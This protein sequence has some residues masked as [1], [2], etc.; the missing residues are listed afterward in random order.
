M[1]T[2][3]WENDPV[4]QA[5]RTAGTARAAE[6]ENWWVKDSLVQTAPE[7]K[8]EPRPEDQSFLRSVADVPLGLTKGAV[9]GVRLIADAFGANN[10]VS[11]TIRGVED[12]VGGLMSAQS[13]NDAREMARIMK[14]AEDKGALDQ[15]QAAVKAISVAPIDTLTQILGTA[16]P[17][18]IG[19]VGAALARAGALAATGVS[20][21]IGAGMGAG[22]VKSTIFDATKEEL[23]K[24]KVPEAEAIKLAEQA[25]EYGGK[26][27]DQILLGA[28]FGVLGGAT[29]IEPALAKAMA[30]RILAKTATEEAATIAAETAAKEAAKGRIR[31]GVEGAIKESI[32]EALQAGQEQI[33][34]NIA[35][36]R[37][38][39]DVPTM[40]GVVGAA[41]LEGL[42]GA[43][44]G[45]GIGARGARRQLSP[46]ATK[47][48]RL[49]SALDSAAETEGAIN[50]PERVSVESLGDVDR[51]LEPSDGVPVSPQATE[52]RAAETEAAGLGA[53]ERAASQLAERE[54]AV[55]NTLVEENGALHD[56]IGATLSK[57]PD[58]LALMERLD[59]ELTQAVAA[60][61][62]DAT[63]LDRVRTES[64]V[65]KAFVST[66]AVPATVAPTVEG[67]TVSPDTEGVTPQTKAEQPQTGEAPKFNKDNTPVPSDE[68]MRDAGLTESEIEN[69]KRKPDYYKFNQI[70][71]GF[72]YIAGDFKQITEA[73]VAEMRDF[74]AK[75]EVKYNEDKKKLDE[76][77]AKNDIS[78]VGR[79]LGSDWGGGGSQAN[80]K[81][82]AYAALSRK[83]GFAASQLPSME[84]ILARTQGTTTTAETTPSVG[85]AP[86]GTQIKAPATP[87]PERIT[88]ADLK[89]T[90]TDA[91]N[92]AVDVTF[93]DGSKQTIEQLI[94]PDGKKRWFYEGADPSEG[95][96]SLQ[97]LGNNTKDALLAL[98]Q[99]VNINP[100]FAEKPRTGEPSPAE[101]E[102][103]NTTVARVTGINEAVA[104]AIR[105]EDLNGTLRII[106]RNLTG[107]YSELATR[108]LNL[109]L[110][111][112]I[113]FDKEVLLT[114]KA[115]DRKTS[116]AQN[117][118]FRYIQLTYPDLYNKFFK[119]FDKESQLE[120]VYQGLLFL[121]SGK[122][123]VDPVRAE[124]TSVLEA[125]ND[126]MP[127]LRVP[128]VFF[129]QFD[130]ISL[131]TAPELLRW[132]VGRVTYRTVLHEVAHAASFYAL[133]ADPSEL[134]PQQLKAR[135]KLFEMFE[136]AKTKL[137]K[138]D[139]YGMTD[140]DEFVSEAFT[141][142]RFQDALKSIPYKDTNASIFSRFVRAILDFFGVDN[143]AGNVMLQANELFSASRPASFKPTPV[144]AKKARV[145]KGPITSSWRT[146]ADAAASY[147]IRLKNAIQG[148]EKWETVLRDT[149]KAVWSTGTGAFRTALLGFANLRQLGDLTR[150]KFPQII[151]AINVIEKMLADRGERL[152]KA[153]D[154]T[155]SWVSLQRKDPAQS[156]LMGRIMLE[157]T[158]QGVD[159][160]TAQPGQLS[161][162]FEEAWNGLDGEFKELYGKV[163]D[164]Y[165]SSL[166]EMI[167][168]IKA[169]AQQN[170]NIA[171][172]TKALED[173][174]K[175]FGPTK[176]KG[177]YFPLRRF[178]QYSYQVGK[179]EN[180]EFYMFES[181]AERDLSFEQRQ[182]QL[183]TANPDLAASMYKSNSISEMFNKNSTD[184]V[185]SRVNK[186]IDA[187][188]S[189]TVGDLKEELRDSIN[190]LVY[191]LLP[192][193]SMKKMFINRKAVQGASEDMLRVFATSA[194]HTAYQQSRFN[195][196]EDFMNQLANAD[197]YVKKFIDP[198]QRDIY[199]DFVKE[200]KARSQVILGTEDTS[201]S[202]QVAGKAS[203]LT[204]FYMLSAPFTA[205]LNTLG[206]AQFTMPY[207][208]GRYGYKK[209][210]ALLLKNVGRYFAT[211]PTRTIEPLTAGTFVKMQFPSIV[212]GGKL[213]PLLQQA[214]DRFI[215]DGQINISMTNDA[216]DL[217]ERPS[218][219][220]TGRWSS[221]KKVMSGLFH[222]SERLNR[223]IALMTTFELAYE[224]YLKEP[225][226]LDNGII[227]RDAQ[228]KP[229]PNSPGDA[230]DLAIAEAKDVAGLTLGDFSR[231]FK[232]RYFTSPALS[233]LFKF[234]QYAVM[235]TY[236]TLRNFYLTIGA[237][238][239]TKEI[240]QIKASL[241]EQYKNAV[242]RDTLVAQG[243]A[244]AEAQRK[245]LYKE[246]R[247]R[248]AGILGVAFLM[249]GAEAMPFFWL[250][251]TLL[252]SAFGPGDDEDEFFNWE[253]WF[254]NYAEENLGG[255]AG[256]IFAKMGMDE[257]TA[258][259]AGRAVGESLSRGPL[260]TIT[261]GALASRT[262]IDLK[263]LW[264]RDANYSPDLRDSVTEAMIA[265]AGP[266]VGLGM[267]ILDAAKLMEQGYYQ[268]A[269]EKALP[270]IV[271]KPLTAE[272]YASEG[273]V[274]KSGTTLIDEFSSWELG[275]QALGLQPE[276][277][278]QKQKAAIETKEVEQRILDR[279]TA[280]LNR[281]WLERDSAD[282]YNR[283]L[284]DAM[285]FSYRHPSVAITS[286]TIRDSF[287]RRAKLA[288]DAE[289][290][291]AS[292][293]KKLRPELMD[294]PRYGM[295]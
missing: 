229:I 286:K 80:S 245:E 271:G 66:L 112:K 232:P 100:V 208:G 162:A 244:E 213:D 37:E 23:M 170:D 146:R 110:P 57:S 275:M 254:R 280:I 88:I 59:N 12:Y 272:R 236:A 239:N 183:A 106:S 93:S 155:K 149:R 204:F 26:N 36:Q 141:N 180:K 50:E 238:F 248:L 247:R 203:S 47:E 134:T 14:E 186:I 46:N 282:G 253:N 56:Q 163:R 225:Q 54:A 274:T 292:V 240:A 72:K 48:D 291:G 10:P 257:K 60:L 39:F 233:V 58:A 154:I 251:G 128:G 120:T 19:G 105:N 285:E 222:Q 210:N 107:F 216:M 42:A 231:Q 13:K 73:D 218:E 22:T 41:T 68:A 158:I 150:S 287:K 131:T 33:A 295:D 159:P 152:K 223:E 289:N 211:A 135:E 144:F 283:A 95:T 84:R 234:K 148:R 260:G 89:Q 119:D 53:T 237:P 8:P 193:Q 63:D 34:E 206:F 82:N 168:K 87:A 137:S 21:G 263:N 98:S 92:Q 118:L 20:A 62:Q 191:I 221:V 256:A 79:I 4:A 122:Y 123:A 115:I 40:R 249:G 52:G 132:S 71:Q 276:R 103:L 142:K 97:Y 246:G 273:A 202:A 266:V 252:T 81:E 125:Y 121:E 18:I 157:A 259:Q 219:L 153:E 69:Y 133:R 161:V 31:R 241:E 70:N 111:S 269:F 293:T 235:A 51:G 5:P 94:T 77:F 96:D 201:F 268:R 215:N 174:D 288:T 173:I 130:S 151:G 261:G 1:A 230:F 136:Y 117:R 171:D 2:N 184:A 164:Y 190:Q 179:G 108:L 27:L 139:H 166:D 86:T 214:A 49:I 182:Q 116:G 185:F 83:H 294:L 195:Y 217:G 147:G 284:D 114:R 138:D 127:A 44:L 243:V 16:A 65:L 189:N 200:V 250:L 265:N 160:D 258:N 32:P 75:S 178:G 207:L 24:A 187:A 228:N 279:R 278:A 113:G 177:P 192:Q 55:L 35:L 104:Q 9:T 126:N 29:G 194:V 172:R 145:D 197:E 156:R 6:P 101:V 91:G 78:G 277:L 227:K 90:K 109:N 3:W 74:A 290:F 205:I 196:A 267:N 281:L 28:G 167:A 129:P 169:R 242:D 176:L 198:K 212:E 102:K 99:Q 61:P 45:A 11:N 143:L 124:L 181:R 188:T 270:A 175:Q 264:F 220:Y 262:S 76:A 140:I 224:K 255:A 38:G 85:V 226:K 165:K 30:R 209:A 43:G 25:Q 17:T 7:A 199:D 64:N 67:K 15:V